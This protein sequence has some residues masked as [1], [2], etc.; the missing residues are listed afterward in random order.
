MTINELWVLLDQY[1]EGLPEAEQVVLARFWNWLKAQPAPAPA[2]LWY[3]RDADGD[4]DLLLRGERAGA[5]AEWRRHYQLD[6]DEL[7]TY[8]APVPPSTMGGLDWGA[9]I[10]DPRAL[11]FKPLA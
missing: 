11:H 10:D 3:V 7:P 4:H 6:D 1:T 9:M 2:P 5:L 8:I